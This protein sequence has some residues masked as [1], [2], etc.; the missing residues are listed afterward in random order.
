[1]NNK[2]SGLLDFLMRRGDMLFSIALLGIVFI[3]VLPLPTLLIDLFLTV[4]IALSVLIIL[5][6]SYVKKP[7]DFFVFPTVLL[8]VTLFRLGLNVATTRSILINGDAGH[9]INAFGQFVVQGNVIVGLIVF[10]ILTVINFMVIT[11]GAGRVAEVAARF[12]L[13]A[14]PGKQMSIDADLNSGVISEQ[15]SRERRDELQQE[16]SFYGAMDGA[17][18]FVRGDAVAGI[19]ITGINL[20]GGFA[21]GILQ[22]DLSVTESI[23]KFTLLS[24]GDGLVTQIPALL[25]ST[26]AGILVTRSSSKEGLGGEVTR[27]LF[28]SRRSL[29]A[30]GILLLS[31]MMVPGFPIFVLAVLGS[32]FITLSRLLPDDMEDTKKKDAAKAEK[33]TE[34]GKEAATSRRIKEEEILKVEPLC[35]ELGLNLLPLVHGNV[36]NLL[37]RLTSLRKAISGDMGLLVPS[38]TVRDNSAI[39]PSQYRILLRGHELASGDL[40]PGQLLAMGVGNMQRPLRGRVTTEPA[41]GLPATWIMETDRRD[42]ER[43][44][45]AVVDPLSVLVTHFSEVL[46]NNTSELL[47]RQDVQRLLDALKETNGAVVQEMTTLQ[48]GLGTVHRVLQNLLREGISIREFS[49]ILEKLC[50]QIVHTKNPDELS[51]A[52]R[53]VLTLEIARRCEIHQGKLM[54]IALHPELEQAIAKHIRQTTQ[55]IA[56]VMDPSLSRYLHDQLLAGC[57]ALARQGYSPV[58]L[59]AAPIR[60]GLKRYFNDAFPGLKVIAYQELPPRIAVQAVHNIAPF[61]A[62]MT[63]AGV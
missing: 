31:L 7:M 60:L 46:K 57:E 13:D 41:F 1:M 44:G 36:K 37:D 63:K 48:I 28:A 25:V 16:S 23:S 21:V 6:I 30:T 39:P 12:T 56:L 59:C 54:V 5:T 35:L 52:C 47:T 4:S 15:E 20:I 17:S 3:L 24:V 29:L 42:A 43:M 33:E 62:N 27:Q 38:I 34:E 9:L 40:F 8:F 53:K 51:E 26:A 58:V 11:K 49:M 50:D 55:E 18:K 19:L 61:K 14:L 2:E 45:Y 32:I 10:I 22:M